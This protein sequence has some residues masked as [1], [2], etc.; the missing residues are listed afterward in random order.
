MTADRGVDIVIN[1]LAGDTLR[2]TWELVAPFGA[3]AEIG[4]SDI[5]SRFCISMG[6]FARGVRLEAL[7]LN[8]M[9]KTD[10]GR[11]DDLFSRAMESVLGEKLPR[12]T[13][14][15]KYPMSRIQD[16]MRLMQSGKYIGKITVEAV[17]GDVVQVADTGLSDTNFGG[18]AT[19]VV[20]GGFGGLGIE[21][22]RWM[23]ARGAQ[24][25]I[26]LSRSGPLDESAKALVQ[27]VQ[28]SGT[29]ILTPCCDITDVKGLEEALSKALEG[30]PSV[31]GCIQA[32]TV[33]MDNI[34]TSMISE[35]WYGALHVKAAGSQNLW[36]ALTAN[37]NTLE[38]FTML[39]SLTAITGNVGQSNYSAGNAWQNAFARQL[40]SQGHN[41]VAFNAPVISDSGLVAVRPALKEYLLSIGW[42]YMSTAELIRALDYHCRPVES[43]TVKESQVV[44]MLWLPKYSADERA[45]QAS[46]Q[47]EPMFSHLNLHESYSKTLAFGKHS[48]RKRTIADL[49]AAAE[50]LEDAEKII[51]DAL[52]EQLS[53]ILQCQVTDFDLA[54]SMSIFGVDSLV[55]VELRV[56][57]NKQI[58]AD[59][60]VFDITSGQRIN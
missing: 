46:W 5:E 9:R 18:N 2:A 48:C 51:L 10:P 33:L 30:L 20:S 59:V 28:A 6:T 43:R 44:P 22:I 7:E 52:L 39:S 35:E 29:T 27:E 17:D 54:R 50:T 49:I 15:T 57:I 40:S 58:G 23:V 37:S 13:L 47:H 4:L 11:L 8:Y 38:F 32:S 1:S 21:V 45:E 56:W 16:A 36:T 34:F 41:A 25:L 14:I 24:N 55:A 3:F 19:Y 60:S 42:A 53:T 31:K 12:A 26:V